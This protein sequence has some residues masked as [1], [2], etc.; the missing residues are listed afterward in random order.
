MA[1]RKNGA[2]DGHPRPLHIYLHSPSPC[3]NALICYHFRLV[4]HYFSD[5]LNFSANAPIAVA[6]IMCQ[7]GWSGDLPHNNKPQ[8]RGDDEQERGNAPQADGSAH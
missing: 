3:H 8:A 4:N 7:R 5:S 1:A 2:F 6:Y